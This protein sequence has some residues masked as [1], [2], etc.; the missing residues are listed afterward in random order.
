MGITRDDDDQGKDRKGKINE[1]PK[2]S[3][4]KYINIKLVDFGARSASS[5]TSGKAVIRG[6]AQLSLLLFEADGF[7]VLPQEEGRPQKV[8]RGGSRGAFEEFCQ[9]K[10]G[11]VLALLNPRVLKPFQVSPLIQSFKTCTEL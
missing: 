6:D 1:T 2:S 9:V 7:D 8:Y 4:K 5:A 11:D 3:G 10:E